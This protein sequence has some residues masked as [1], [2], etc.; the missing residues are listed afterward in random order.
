MGS[1]SR[2]ALIEKYDPRRRVGAGST[3][4]IPQPT[5]LKGIDAFGLRC[6][7]EDRAHQTWAVID[8]E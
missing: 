7:Y 8:G 5:P 3:W 6:H 2:E 4:V 1:A